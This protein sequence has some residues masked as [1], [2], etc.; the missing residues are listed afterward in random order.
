MNFHA[1]GLGGVHVSFCAQQRLPEVVNGRTC[2]FLWNLGHPVK[3]EEQKSLLEAEG[4]GLTSADRSRR[5][6]RNQGAN[7]RSG[8]FVPGIQ[9]GSNGRWYQYISYI[10]ICKIDA[11]HGLTPSIHAPAVATCNNARRLLRRRWSGHGLPAR[12]NLPRLTIREKQKLTCTPY[13]PR[14]LR[15]YPVYGQTYTMR[16]P[17]SADSCVEQGKVGGFHA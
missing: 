5:T 2:I 15:G 10:L 11:L 8:A 6:R 1:N 17:E 9:G 12:P 14:L 13:R 3:I 16:A 7:V 4:P